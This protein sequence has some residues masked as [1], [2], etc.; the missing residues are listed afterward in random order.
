[1]D[2][3]SVLGV[4]AS[5]IACIQLAGELLKRVGPS[6]HNKA[7]LNRILQ[8]VSG[9]NGAYEGLKLC[10]QFNENDQARLS[11]LQHLEGLLKDTK[12][13]LEF[14]ESRLKNVRFVGQYIIGSNWDGRFKKH[15]KRLEDAKAL[16][17]LAMHADQQ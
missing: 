3:F 9:F 13:V 12:E 14:L 16:F 8:V 7:D 2:S 6:D 11:M 5:I 10:L 4:T 15:L 1:M 17:E